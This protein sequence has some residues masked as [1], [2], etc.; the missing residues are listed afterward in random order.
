MKLNFRQGG[1]RMEI[2]KQGTKVKSGSWGRSVD[3]QHTV[4]HTTSSTVNQRLIVCSSDTDLPTRQSNTAPGGSHLAGII[5]SYQARLYVLAGPGL[6]ALQVVPLELGTDGLGGREGERDRRV[7]TALCRGGGGQCPSYR[8]AAPVG[9]GAGR[10]C[11]W[12]IEG[13]GRNVTRAMDHHFV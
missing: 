3:W 13:A 4:C 8:P 9:G 2:D 5:V 12:G 11:V 1:R 10:M 7:P 6:L